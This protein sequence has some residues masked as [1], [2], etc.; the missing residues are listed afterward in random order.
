MVERTIAF[1]DLAGFSALTETHGDEDAA[2]LAE[3]F[4]ALAC[5]ALLP[6]ERLV[7]SIGDAVMLE[8]PG[9]EAGAR[10]V[11]RLCARTDNEEAFPVVRAGIHHGPV[12]MRGDDLFGAVVNLASRVAAQAAGGQ[13]LVTG[14]V[15]DAALD[16]GLDARSLGSFALRNV[17]EPVALYEIRPCP[18]PHDRVID[19]VCRM[20]VDRSVAPGRITHDGRE[21]WFCS[22]SCVAAFVADPD[23]YAAE[24]EPA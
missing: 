13:V 2:T 3:R 6:G 15:A 14:V 19:P 9:P 16:A 11:G 10:R 20:A 12:V 17:A 5:K 7:K 24:D 8:A 21:R 23:R 4:C 18:R 22:L 1:V